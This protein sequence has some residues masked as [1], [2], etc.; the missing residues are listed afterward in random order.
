MHLKRFFV[1]ILHANQIKRSQSNETVNNLF[2]FAVR[3][4]RPIS[5]YHVLIMPPINYIYFCNDKTLMLSLI[6][7]IF[8]LFRDVLLEFTTIAVVSF[9]NTSLQ[10]SSG[11]QPQ[12]FERGKCSSCISHTRVGLN[13]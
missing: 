8:R 4:K 3:K 10:L 9:L 12:T 5:L 13:S 7:N 11:P 6:R 2:I 1:P